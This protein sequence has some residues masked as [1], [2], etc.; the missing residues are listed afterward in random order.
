MAHPTPH[1]HVLND[2]VTSKRLIRYAP[3]QHSWGHAGLVDM[4]LM[5][6]PTGKFGQTGCCITCATS[7]VAAFLESALLNRGQPLT[8]S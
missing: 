8:R 2:W 3:P 7:M 6:C 4:I 1:H 5:H